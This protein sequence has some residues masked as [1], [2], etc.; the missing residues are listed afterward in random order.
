[1]SISTLFSFLFDLTIQHAT[2]PQEHISP[3]VQ[4]KGNMTFHHCHD[5][6]TPELVHLRI[7]NTI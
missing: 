1:M 7:M 2:H 4:I 3:T 6:M 5:P